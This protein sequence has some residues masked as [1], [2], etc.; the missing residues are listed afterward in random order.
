[1]KRSKLLLLLKTLSPEECNRLKDYIRSPYFNKDERLIRL[2][3]YF[4]RLYP[5]FNDAEL[6]K[7]AV[8]KSVF[9]GMPFDKAYF[10][11]LQHYLFRLAEQFLAHQSIR[12][13]KHYQDKAILRS[14]LERRLEKHYAFKRKQL[15]RPNEQETFREENYHYHQFEL[16]KTENERFIVQRQR[17]AHSAIQDSSTALDTFY[18]IQKLKFLAEILDRQKKFPQSY[19]IQEFELLEPLIN[20]KNYSGE[21]YI[22]VYWQLV[23]M[24]MNEEEVD[25]FNRFKALLDQHSAFINPADLKR[26]FLFAINY[27]VRKIGAGQAFQQQLLALYTNGLANGTLLEYGLLSPWTYKNVVQ[28]GLAL[29]KIT[30]VE[31]FI[32]EYAQKLPDHLYKDA[33]YYNQAAIHYSKNDYEQAMFYL[34]KVQYSDISYKLWSKEL[35]LKLYYELGELEA[36][37]SLLI[38]FEQLIKRNKQIQRP[39]KEAYRNFLKIVAKLVRKNYK[40]ELLEKEIQSKTH[41]RERNWLLMNV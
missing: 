22:L 4:F 36:L 41:L 14:Y 35:L 13:N 11:H 23:Q 16:A 6:E 32:E 1:M 9:P 26:L 24:L 18:I 38:S 29:G 27:C 20:G 31:Q 19:D 25:Y 30:W 12:A 34:N 28:L 3:D 21:P 15:S 17:V 37:H 7:E 33:Y 2:F 39:Q 10:N 40:K 8:F 5:D